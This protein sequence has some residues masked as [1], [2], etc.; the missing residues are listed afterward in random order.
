MTPEQFVAKW[1]ASQ[2]RERHPSQEQFI[3]LCHMLDEKT[4]GCSN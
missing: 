1:K 3:D 2:L 4:A